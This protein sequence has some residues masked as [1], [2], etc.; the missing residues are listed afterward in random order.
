MCNECVICCL[1]Q[2]N[3]LVVTGSLLTPIQ[4]HKGV[5]IVR[6]DMEIDHEEADTIIVNQV[7]FVLPECA[8]VI[9][10]DT[11]VFLLLVQHVFSKSIREKV[12]MTSP[13]KGRGC[14]TLELQLQ[15]TKTL[16][17]KS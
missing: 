5:V 14:L 4:L 9:A 10:D 12:Y 13:I 3:S 7:T 15:S 1:F 16:Y 2:H 17:L 6:H 11:D 8:L